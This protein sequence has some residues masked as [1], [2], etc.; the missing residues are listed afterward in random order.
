MMST[1]KKGFPKLNLHSELRHLLL[2][3]VI[4]TQNLNRSL[5]RRRRKKRRMTR[6]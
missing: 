1:V 2:N 6:K 5:R 3:R 4:Q